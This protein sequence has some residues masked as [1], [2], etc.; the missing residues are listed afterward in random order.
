MSDVA[1]PRRFS[2][3]MIGPF[4]ALAPCL[5]MALAAFVPQPCH[6]SQRATM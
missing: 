2:A 5:F 4:K 3:L 6:H 1:V